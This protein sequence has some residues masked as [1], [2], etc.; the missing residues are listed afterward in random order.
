MDPQMHS[1]HCLDHISE[2]LQ[3]L[4]EHPSRVSAHVFLPFFV[5]EVR[6]SQLGENIQDL[7]A[8]QTDSQTDPFHLREGIFFS[9]EVA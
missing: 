2:I 9:L 6:P 8:Q 4:F 5:K 3:Q 1:G 7:L